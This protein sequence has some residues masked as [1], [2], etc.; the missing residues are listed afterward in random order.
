MADQNRKIILN[1]LLNFV[2]RSMLYGA[3]IDLTVGKAV[4]HAASHNYIS[5]SGLQQ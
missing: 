5:E 4:S 2:T 3:K 1:L